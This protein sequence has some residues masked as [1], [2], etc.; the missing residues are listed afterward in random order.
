MVRSIRVSLA[1]DI[2]IHSRRFSGLLI[3]LFTWAQA[4]ADWARCVIRLQSSGEV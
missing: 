2:N 3:R 1:V 4:L